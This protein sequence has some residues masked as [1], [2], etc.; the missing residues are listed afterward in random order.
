[1][2]NNSA[3]RLNLTSI[4]RQI[5]FA[6][7]M[8]RE[9]WSTLEALSHLEFPLTVRE[10]CDPSMMAL[11]RNDLVAL[12]SSGDGTTAFWAATDAGSNLVML[13]TEEPLIW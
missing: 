3:N 1:M 2:Q 10:W 5:E 12:T 7:T 8:S 4:V 11:F 13:R 6:R 9:Q